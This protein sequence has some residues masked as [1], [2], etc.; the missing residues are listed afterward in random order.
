MG[1]NLKSGIHRI[2][3]EMDKDMTI[4]IDCPNFFGKDANSD[5]IIYVGDKKNPDS[6]KEKTINQEGVKELIKF[7]V[8]R[9]LE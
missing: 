4:S 7:L 9:C 1:E 2:E 5:I 8:N 3:I 6:Y